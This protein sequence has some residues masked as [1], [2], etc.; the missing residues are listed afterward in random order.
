MSQ[1]DAALKFVRE[2]LKSP[3]YA[4]LLAK[5]DDAECVEAARK[6]IAGL[7]GDAKVKEFDVFI[8]QA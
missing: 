8:A 7:F 1:K 2:V 3:K 6:Q 4:D 5:H